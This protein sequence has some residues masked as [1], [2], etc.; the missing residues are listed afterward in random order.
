MKIRLIIVLALIF[1][2][3]FST[4][5]SFGMEYSQTPSQKHFT[6]IIMSLPGV[7]SAEWDSPISLWVKTSSKA[8]GSPPN[9][10]KAKQLADI[11]ADRGRT[12]LRQPFCVH[13]YQKKE[14][15]LASSCVY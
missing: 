12:A 14:S 10:Q 9:P 1:A 7:I 4:L 11:L 3:G 8:V 5:S 2:T 6:S 15:E 13:I